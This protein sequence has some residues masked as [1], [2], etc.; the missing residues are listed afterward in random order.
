MQKRKNPNI[1]KTKNQKKTN[2]QSFSQT[3]PF[4]ITKTQIK[5]KTKPIKYQT[6]PLKINYINKPGRKHYIC[7][8]EHL[9][10][11]SSLES[12]ENIV[13]K[14]REERVKL[15]KTQYQALDCDGSRQRRLRERE[16]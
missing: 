4:Q 6:K 3:Y 11:E 10:S 14:R 15:Q 13:T 16:R 5:K 12:L 1:S 7:K 9:K 2:S 8:E